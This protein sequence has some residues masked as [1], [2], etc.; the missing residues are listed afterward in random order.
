MQKR[1]EGLPA[2]PQ[3]QAGARWGPGGLL[4][5]GPSPWPASRP[6]FLHWKR[7][8]SQPS[9]VKKPPA[10]RFLQ[11]AAALT[12][13]KFSVSSA[14]R[15]SLHWPSHNC[16]PLN[17]PEDPALRGREKGLSLFPARSVLSFL[18]PPLPSA[19]P[20]HLSAAVAPPLLQ[21][22]M[23]PH[24]SPFSCPCLP[25]SSSLPSWSTPFLPGSVLSEAMAPGK[26]LR[27]TSQ[28]PQVQTPA[29]MLSFRFSPIK[30]GC[31]GNPG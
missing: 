20:A 21:S 1:A 26:D 13:R 23:G 28:T 19:L 11:E 31:C 27:L 7:R 8:W 10:S 5:T 22:P 25:L 18:P 17:S 30:Q 12:A 6:V 16:L 29:L 4:Y 9:V 24:C 3:R 15:L 14:P 2:S